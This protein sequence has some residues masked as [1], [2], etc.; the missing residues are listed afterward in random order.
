MMNL[1][2]TEEPNKTKIKFGS[3]DRKNEELEE[4]DDDND[5]DF[6]LQS[7]DKMLDREEKLENH[8]D[9]SFSQSNKNRTMTMTM[10]RNSI[11]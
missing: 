7:L 8:Q 3:S 2:Q 11:E 4:D 5:D 9:G 1:V 10:T 6:K